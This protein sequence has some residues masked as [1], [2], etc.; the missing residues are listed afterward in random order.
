MVQAY[1]TSASTLNLVRAFTQGGFA[2]LRSVHAWNQGFMRNPAYSR[3]EELAQEIDRAVRFMDAAGADF[4]AL[5]R[6][7]FFTAHEALLLDYERPLTRIDSRSGLPYAT[8]GHFLWIG[9]RTRDLDGA[10]VEFLSKVRNPIGVKLGPTT[11][12]EDALALVD[13]LD[14][15]R[16]PGRLT[17]ITR[18]GAKRIRD[19]LPELVEKVTAAGVSVAWVCDPMHGNTWE[20]SSGY[21]TRSF[22]DVIR[23]CADP[24]R[25]SGWIDQDI[26]TAYTELHELGWAHSVEAWQDGRLVG[27]L[28]GI[29]VGGLFAGESMF[30]RERD[31]SK[32]ALVTLVDM[33]RADGGAD[34][35]LDVQW[36]TE[37][38]T[39]LGAVDVP[40]PAYL[41]M[42]DRALRRPSPLLVSAA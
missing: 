37:H 7:D 34:R 13:K 1:N 4:E 24:A 6:T 32:V 12:P 20:S 21:K 23:A 40:R 26:V 18:M 10:H 8:S 3:Y 14:P 15:E 35:L 42:L 16:E 27:G 9:E 31:A 33:L 39:S 2:D 36:A 5:R 29:A 28:Y 19:V 30:H 41:S 25:D 17:F 38:L 11:T 22:D